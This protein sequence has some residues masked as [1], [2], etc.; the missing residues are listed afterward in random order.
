MIYKGEIIQ[1]PEC[2]LDLYKVTRDI[3]CGSKLRANAIDPIDLVPKLHKGDRGSCVEC[4]TD[5]ISSYAQKY[6][7][8]VGWV[9]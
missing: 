4:G 9:E 6:I 1:C 5:F 7:K 2:E 8:N 3:P